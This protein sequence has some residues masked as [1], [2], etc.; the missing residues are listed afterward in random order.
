[1]RD[2]MPGRGTTMSPESFAA[3]FQE[4]KRLLWAIAAGITA[5]RHASEDIVQESAAIAL[6]KLSDFNPATSFT[7]WMG[8]IVRFTALNHTRT[9]IRRNTHPN[10]DLD[11]GADPEIVVRSNPIT[12][13]GELAPNQPEF[14][15]HVAAALDDLEP[16]AR[17]CLL[18]RAVVGLSYKEIATAM[19]LPE[20][21][22][23]SHVFRARKRLRDELR[24]KGE[25]V[26]HR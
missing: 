3:R 14:D 13:R 15:D 26:A 12:P 20:G 8:Q 7:A 21:T 18:L 23:M 6:T 19:D 17:A 4:H 1:M 2:G 22:A 24:G 16:P 9:T 25:E 10:A 11:K 5:D